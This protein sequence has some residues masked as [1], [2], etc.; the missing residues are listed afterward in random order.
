MAHIILNGTPTD[1]EHQTLAQLI[2]ALD[3]TNKR[4]A[5]EVNQHIVSKSKLEQYV[6]QDQ[7]QIEVIHAVGG[8]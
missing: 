5:V 8:G 3:L 7:D 1:T 2:H 4:F 6:I